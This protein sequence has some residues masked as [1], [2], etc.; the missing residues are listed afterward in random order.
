MRNLRDTVFY[1]KTNV[2]QDF[3]ICISVPLKKR[4]PPNFTLG[5]VVRRCSLKK[6]FLENSQ[7]SHENTCA[8]DSFFNKIV[9]LRSKVK[10]QA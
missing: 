5:A 3:H 10:L 4:P 7:N 9:G 6:V 2:L 1:V 8:R